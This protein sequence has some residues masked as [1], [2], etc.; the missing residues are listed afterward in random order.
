LKRREIVTG[1]VLVAAAFYLGWRLLLIVAMSSIA[2]DDDEW[3]L[4]QTGAEVIGV[5]GDRTTILPVI[6]H[7]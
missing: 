3:I 2:A 5:L 1:L 4:T 7:R 6:K